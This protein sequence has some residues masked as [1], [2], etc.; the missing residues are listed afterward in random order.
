MPYATLQD[1]IGRFGERELGQIAQGYALE[2]I[3]AERVERAL[4]DAEAEIDGYVGT[5]YPL[6]ID[7]VPALLT[8][9]ACDVA[10]YRLYDDAA[11]DEV[12]RR[13]EDVARVL[14]HIADGTVSLGT[15][16]GTPTL[17][18]EVQMVEH[19]GGA[20]FRRRPGGGLR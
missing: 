8:R 2:V 7:P 20:L 15:R 17:P 5:R 10:R 1:M 4:A 3:D 6:P 12:R 19:T 11:P 14:R 18:Q 13:Y 9:A 16:P